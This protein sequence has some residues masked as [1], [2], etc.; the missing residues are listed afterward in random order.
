MLANRDTTLKN[1]PISDLHFHACMFGR[2]IEDKTLNSKQLLVWEHLK[3]LL[4]QSPLFD[5]QQ[6]DSRC[7]LREVLCDI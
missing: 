3:D 6:R 1:Y 2:P 7:L 5:Q 4:S